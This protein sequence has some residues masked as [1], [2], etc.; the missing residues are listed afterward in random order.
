MTEQKELVAPL[1]EPQPEWMAL[2]RDVAVNPALIEWPRDE[3]GI[4]SELKR[5][6]V[7]AAMKCKGNPDKERILIGTI[8]V[9]LAHT[10][11]RVVKDAEIQA[12][13]VQHIK[14]MAEM[15]K[16]VERFHAPKGDK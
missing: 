1:V 16:P 10:R 7:Q 13:R 8:M 5:A 2:A 11:K 14:K 12:G 4:T 9:G 6:F 15:R 3:H